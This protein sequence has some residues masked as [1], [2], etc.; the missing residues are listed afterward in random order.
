[1][2][3]SRVRIETCDGVGGSPPMTGS[4]LSRRRGERDCALPELGA[5]RR[6]SV[7]PP[8]PLRSTAFCFT[9]LLLRPRQRRSSILSRRHRTLLLTHSKL[10]TLLRARFVLGCIG[11]GSKGKIDLFPETGAFRETV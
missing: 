9:P 3:G 11:A 1:M 8:A 5:R 7:R 10:L 6:A 2:V 4:A